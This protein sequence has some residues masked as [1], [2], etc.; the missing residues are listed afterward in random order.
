MATALLPISLLACGH[1]PA[2]RANASSEPSSVEQA[3][4]LLK[5]VQLRFEERDGKPF[6][7]PLVRVTVAG[8]P[9]LMI[10]DTGANSHVLANSFA[11]RH[12]L[13]MKE[14]ESPLVHDHG[15]VKSEA[16]ILSSPNLVIDGF[17]EVRDALVIALD[18]P[19]IFDTLQ[20]GGILSPQR[21]AGPDDSVVLDFPAKT[22]EVHPTAAALERLQ[23]PNLHPVPVSTCNVDDSFLYAIR[24]TVNGVPALLEIDTGADRGDI[25][26][27]SELGHKL[28]STSLAAKDVKYSVSG[29]METRSVKS[30]EIRM[31]ERTETVDIAIV[32]GKPEACDE[33]VL[34][35]DL[36]RRCVFVVG[37]SG[38]AACER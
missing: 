16:S 35:M 23:R 5:R 38:A 11:Q 15:G 6:P 37:H 8:T 2:K 36:L 19:P 27:E 20:I 28:Q 32:P 21:L 34:G 12:G 4:P 30:A 22:L 31:G 33:G 9:T 7:Y 10:V 3:K 17:G 25:K 13:S 18:L 14:G 26:A 24:A 1:V 29:P